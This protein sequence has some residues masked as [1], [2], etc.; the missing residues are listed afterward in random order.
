MGAKLQH[1][2]Q[3]SDPKLHLPKVT[4]IMSDGQE[5]DKKLIPGVL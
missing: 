3:R 5:Q 4:L 2:G 1:Q